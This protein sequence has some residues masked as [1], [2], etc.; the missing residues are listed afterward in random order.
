MSNAE[1]VKQAKLVLKSYLGHEDWEVVRTAE[2]KDVKLVRGLVLLTYHR[3]E[4][5]WSAKIIENSLEKAYGE[6]ADQ[7][8]KNLKYKLEILS[9]VL[10][11]M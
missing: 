5:R 11:T 9:T 4:K 7:A 1:L 8:Y 2:W 10:C 3:K 6:T